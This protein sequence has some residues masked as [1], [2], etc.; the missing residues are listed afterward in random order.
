MTP[1]VSFTV[2]VTAASADG[3]RPLLTKTHGP[4]PGDVRQYDNAQYFGFQKVEVRDAGEMFELLEVLGPEAHFAIVRGAL[5]PG[6]DFSQP[7]RRLLHK[8]PDGTVPT[9][10]NGT[11]AGWAAFDLD[12]SAPLPGIDWRASPRKA[13]QAIARRDLPP[14]AVEADHVMYWS[15]S[16]GFSEVMKLRVFVLL[17]QPMTSVD[18]KR[19]MKAGT[20]AVDLALY[21]DAQLHYTATPIFSGSVVD[22]LPY[23][24]HYFF[25][26]THR[27]ALAPPLPPTLNA[28]LRQAP[29]AGT[30]S[31]LPSR[32][33]VTMPARRVFG[34][35]GG[36]SSA[37]IE[38]VIATMGEQSAGMAGFHVPW[39]RALA[40]FYAQN[41]PEADPR[42]LIVRLA[43]VIMERGQ[44][45]QAY[46]TRAVHGMFGRAR[47]LAALER[48]R[49]A[50]AAALPDSFA[51]SF[52]SPAKGDRQ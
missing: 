3:H 16:Q 27:R 7:Q 14:W 21:S 41:G 9:L 51:T 34:G 12:R 47:V 49:R 10:V 15:S 48:E 50:A 6:V 29:A 46:V 39:N 2:L 17:E 35:R 22:P 40:I 30:D 37:A 19:L 43:R 5:A 18:L 32:M 8:Q 23:G 42:P 31:G 20:C 38:A 52:N 33:L 26:G 28:N 44:R 11:L 45:D 1:S 13:A 36:S 25:K 4:N 24:R